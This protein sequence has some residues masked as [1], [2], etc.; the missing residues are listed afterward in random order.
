MSCSRR[1]LCWPPH[2]VSCKSMAVWV[3]STPAAGACA[4]VGGGGWAWPLLATRSVAPLCTLLC[5]WGEVPVEAM[6]VES[7]VDAIRGAADAVEA[8]NTGTLAVALVTVAAGPAHGPGPA[9]IAARQCDRGAPV[10]LRSRRASG[11]TRMCHPAR[12]LRRPWL[13]RLVASR[14]RAARCVL[15]SLQFSPLL[16]IPPSALM[17]T[18]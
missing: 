10:A 1:G 6:R 13:G 18:Q 3:H 8:V 16:C 2:K 12:A 5:A 7:T 15:V 4:E 9:A 14:E 11:G 17:K